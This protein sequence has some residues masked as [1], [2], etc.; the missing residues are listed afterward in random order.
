M[1]YYNYFNINEEKKGARIVSRVMKRNDQ[2]IQELNE[3]RGLV[4]GALSLENV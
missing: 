4:W 3:G 2:E 1:I